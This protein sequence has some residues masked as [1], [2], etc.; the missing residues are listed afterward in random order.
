MQQSTKAGENRSC[1]D[2]EHVRYERASRCS[3]LW[4]KNI[5]VS[6]CVI[7]TSNGSQINVPLTRLS[8]VPAPDPPAFASW[9]NYPLGVHDCSAVTTPVA[10]LS[11][12]LSDLS[13][14]LFS[15]GINLRIIDVDHGNPP[16]AGASGT[17]TTNQ[18]VAIVTDHYSGSPRCTQTLYERSSDVENVLKQPDIKLPKIRIM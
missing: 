1:E 2:T 10:S 3:R 13:S 9:R 18:S 8:P 17:G 4:S 15:E 7:M 5:F 16:P 14:V 12:R 11:A 6:H